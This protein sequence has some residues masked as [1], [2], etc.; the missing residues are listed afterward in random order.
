MRSISPDSLGAGPSSNYLKREMTLVG[1]T[2]GR[3][4]FCLNW[5][6]LNA[7]ENDVTEKGNQVIC[8][9][10]GPLFDGE[11]KF[12]ELFI[13]RVL[14]GRAK[15]REKG[16]RAHETPHMKEEFK[17]AQDQCHAVPV[18]TEHGSVISLANQRAM[19]LSLS[20]HSRSY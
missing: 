20:C 11:G 13:S 16:I 19:A 5:A 18:E 6:D 8:E 1:G 17:S 4:R 2:T 3:F 12:F 10:T 9:R 15:Q 14:V 7:H